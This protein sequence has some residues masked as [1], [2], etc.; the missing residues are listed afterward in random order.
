MPGITEQA[1]VYGEY[2]DIPD[3]QQAAL[4]S[5]VNFFEL[6][7]EKPIMF[8]RQING[9]FAVEVN[10]EFNSVIGRSQFLT[11]WITGERANVR[12]EIVN[13]K[14]GLAKAFMPDDPW[15]HNRIIIA[16][17]RDLQN[18]HAYH[19]KDGM[20]PGSMLREEINALY[21]RITADAVE[22]TVINAQG[23][24][25]GSYPTR[26][27]AE[28]DIAQNKYK[29]YKVVERK[30]RVK[31]D[32][33]TAMI[34]QWRRGE[35]SR[36]GWTDCAQF[37]VIR[38]EVSRKIEESRTAIKMPANMPIDPA[39]M[40]AAVVQAIR[41]MPIEERRQLLL[42]VTK[43]QGN[44]EVFD[45]KEPAQ[46]PIGALRKRAKELKIKIPK[47]ATRRDIIALIR[48]KGIPIIDEKANAIRD[49]L[50]AKE[51]EEEVVS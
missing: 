22:Y 35:G 46:L 8:S 26:K 6:R 37:K 2:S 4:R 10:E 5:G 33:I 47:Q 34:A 43:K 30:I 16:D 3:K 23:K 36:Y 15:W 45:G 12:F 14:T 18:I 9:P 17:N 29:N 19:T 31:S 28:D 24:M 49:E 42:D 40:S 1:R 7:T 48:E 41:S 25:I 11:N 20:F 13:P 32:E 50:T 51:N 44:E 21:S 27:E 38:D 39:T